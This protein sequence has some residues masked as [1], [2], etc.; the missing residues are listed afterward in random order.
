MSDDLKV[1]EEGSFESVGELIKDFEKEEEEKK[2]NHPIKY[3]W[4][5]FTA[6]IGR[7]VDYIKRIPMRVRRFIQRG[8]RGYDEVT[9]WKLDTVLT[10]IIIP[11]LKK[12][13]KRHCGYPG[14]LTDEKWEEILDDMIFAWEFKKRIQDSDILGDARPEESYEKM[15]EFQDELSF[16]TEV[17][18]EEDYDKY[19]KG[20]KLFIKY[21]DNLWD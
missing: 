5:K 1:V 16:I 18:P 19:Q 4:D 9:W 11:N 7:K 14:G 3:Y 10:D 13:K 20:M 2:K 17:P 6:G 15:K 8:K 21:F 12:L